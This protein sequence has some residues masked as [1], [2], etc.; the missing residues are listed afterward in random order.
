MFVFLKNHGYCPAARPVG[1]ASSIVH[2]AHSLEGG[3]AS[4]ACES[5]DSAVSSYRH[6]AC[7]I[8][9]SSHIGLFLSNRSWYISMHEICVLL[10]KDNSPCSLCTL[11]NCSHTYISPVRKICVLWDAVITWQE[12]SE[13]WRQ[14]PPHPIP[15][16][17]RGM[18]DSGT[19]ADLSNVLPARIAHLPLN[20]ISHEYNRANFKINLTVY[21]KKELF[22]LLKEQSP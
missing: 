7:M 3:K 8:Y 21:L 17:E 15:S 11:P 10:G 13:T 9:L 12:A 5:A 20:D 2:Y 6:T 4:S 18:E 14:S 19:R 16:H 22:F 1:F